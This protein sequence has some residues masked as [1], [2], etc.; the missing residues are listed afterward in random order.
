MLVEG[1]QAVRELLRHRAGEVRD[2]YLTAAAVDLHPEL[3]E[4][5]EAS[6]RWVH[7]V[8]PAVAEAMSPDAQGVIAVAG[9]SA[10]GGALPSGVAAEAETWLVLAQG[11]D[12]GNV[13]TMIRTADAMGAAGVLVCAGTV[14]VTAP[15]VVRSSAG[16]VFHLPVVAVEDF[17][18]ARDLLHAR[19]AVLLGTS[20]A[21]GALDLDDMMRAS[22]AARRAAGVGAGAE[23]G[24]GASTGAERSGL[25]CLA[26]SHAW[27]M[28]N[29]ARGLS[30][31]EMEA[32]DHLVRIPMTGGA[33][34]L[35]VASAAAMCLFASQHVRA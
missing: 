3:L 28:G 13:G 25:T 27:A 7:E 8:T 34:S 5:A 29:E 2:V 24:E 23:A 4:A 22:T 17:E 11:R 31:A 21:R 6:T 30:E 32:C 33:E 19:G 1:P 10:V 15:K 18:R 35:N 16:S 20:G 9:L 12:P 26:G 14:E